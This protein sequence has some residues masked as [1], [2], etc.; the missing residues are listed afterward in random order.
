MCVCVCLSVSMYVC[1]YECMCVNKII[2]T[3]H[4]SKFLIFEKFLSQ[5]SYQIQTNGENFH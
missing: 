2:Q 1:M 5:K 3:C 4:V